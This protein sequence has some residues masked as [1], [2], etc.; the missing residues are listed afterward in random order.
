VNNS[1][2]ELFFFIGNDT[3]V[4]SYVGEEVAVI[5]MREGSSSAGPIIQK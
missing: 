2:P 5:T 1:E 4:R 3:S